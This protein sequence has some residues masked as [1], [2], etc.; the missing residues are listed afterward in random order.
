MPEGAAHISDSALEVSGTR[1]KKKDPLVQVGALDASNLIAATSSPRGFAA[2]YFSSVKLN[3][4]S[5]LPPTASPSIN[6]CQDGNPCLYLRGSGLETKMEST[7]TFARNCS[8][9]GLAA[10]TSTDTKKVLVSAP[11]LAIDSSSAVFSPK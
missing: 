8:T 2:K 6:Y 10:H 3:L 11:A 1:S 9:R 4:L 5:F 7:S